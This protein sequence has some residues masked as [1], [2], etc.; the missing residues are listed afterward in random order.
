M[1]YSAKEIIKVL[2]DNGWYLDR[3]R[4]SHHVYKNDILQKS[5]P[6]PVHGNRD[7][8]KGIF[9]K[10]LKQCEIGKDEI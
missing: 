7:L 2:E 3:V 5:V 9:Y 4:G 6:I 8:G 10:I 1:A